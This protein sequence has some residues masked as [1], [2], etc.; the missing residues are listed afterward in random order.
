[1]DYTFIPMHFSPLPVNPVGQGPHTAPTPGAGTSWHSTPLK[2]VT[3]AQ[4][5]LSSLHVSP[6]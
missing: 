3:S 4:P 6:S 1:M 5:F 2:Q